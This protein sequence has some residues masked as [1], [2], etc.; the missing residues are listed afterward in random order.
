MTSWFSRLA[1]YHFQVPSTFFKYHIPCR[2]DS[3]KQDLD[4]M[5]PEIILREIGKKCSQSEIDLYRHT[6]SYW[7]NSF[8]PY[9]GKSTALPRWVMPSY[10][11]RNTSHHHGWRIC[12]LCMRDEPCLKL[13]SRLL[14]S[15]ACIKHKVLLID[16]CKNCEAP[17]SSHRV[18]PP[19]FYDGV[20]DALAF[21]H[22]CGFDFRTQTP[23]IAAQS[24]IDMVKFCESA[25]IDGT[26]KTGNISFSYS[27]LFFE[28]FR[29][30]CKGLMRPKQ[31]EILKNSLFEFNLD[32]PAALQQHEVEFLSIQD[33]CQIL[34]AG[35]WLLD[36][37]PYRFVEESLQLG[38]GYSDW[39]LPR[40][41]VPYW[42]GDV[43]KKHLRK[44]NITAKPR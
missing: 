19:F 35:R 34:V 17:I 43:V 15:V 12:I 41:V 10:I 7:R 21:C 20:Y 40:D 31:R 5:C 33:A 37:W 16:T 23:C 24:E 38:L 4:V 18:F 27:H 14:F 22:K 30:I 6:L 1:L 29:L 39:I 26:C 44:G 28:G 36:D 13:F 3:W 42:F 2:A 25:I 32:L 8:D 9:D 11:R